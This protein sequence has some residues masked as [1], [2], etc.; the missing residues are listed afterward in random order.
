MPII[1]DCTLD[2]IR[3]VVDEA[4]SKHQAQA[5]GT[6]SPGKLLTRDEV[7]EMCHISKPTFHAWV[8][9]G[10]IE[11]QKVGGRTLVKAESLERALQTKKV[12][13]YKHKD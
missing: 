10:A 4:L 3:R 6:G 5:G 13:R 7:C 12:Y 1:V 9:K 11:V 2:D 8:N